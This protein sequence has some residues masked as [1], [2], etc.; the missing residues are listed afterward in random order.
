MWV[1]VFGKGASRSVRGVVDCGHGWERIAGCVA[2]WSLRGIL[3]E[4]LSGG[5]RNQDEMFRLVLDLYWSLNESTK[6]SRGSFQVGSDVNKKCLPPEMI[7]E[8]D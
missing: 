3:R 2:R 4:R 6:K 8:G 1:N 7:G 5:Y